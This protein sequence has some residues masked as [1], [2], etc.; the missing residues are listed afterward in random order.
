MHRLRGPQRRTHSVPVVN[1]VHWF[2]Y[3]TWSSPVR[4]KTESEE[5]SDEEGEE[6]EESEEESEEEV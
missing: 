6:G 4:A 5:E 3:S 2:P 1:R